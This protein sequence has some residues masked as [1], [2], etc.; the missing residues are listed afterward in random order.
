M[1]SV[2]QLTNQLKFRAPIEPRTFEAFLKKPNKCGFAFRFVRM[3]DSASLSRK[4]KKLEKS[5]I[6][7]CNTKKIFS[8]TPR[9]I[10]LWVKS[11]RWANGM[12]RFGSPSTWALLQHCKLD[13]RW[14][15]RAVWWKPNNWGC[16][17]RP[18]KCSQ[19]RLP[20][21]RHCQSLLNRPQVSERFQWQSLEK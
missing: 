11:P 17:A 14:N 20:R 5:I 16:S 19:R 12:L 18:R 15:M 1:S 2:S 6:N 7:F 9:S 8:F 3:L 10:R 21:P 13:R 4:M